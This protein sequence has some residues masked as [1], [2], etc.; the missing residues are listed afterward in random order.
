M[1][2]RMLFIFGALVTLQTYNASA[3]EAT[4]VQQGDNCGTNCSW[5]IDSNNKLTIWATDGE[6]PGSM[7]DYSLD[8]WNLWTSA[9]WKSYRDTVTTVEFMDGI[10][11]IGKEAFYGMKNILDVTIP[12]SVDTF[13]RL[14]FGNMLGPE[15][16]TCSAENLERYLK[17]GL[18]RGNGVIHCTSGDCEQALANGIAANGISPTCDRVLSWTLDT[19]AGSGSG[20]D[21][22]SA[23][24]SDSASD[25]GS[26]ETSVQ[27]ADGSTTLY[28]SDGNV[29]GYRGKRI[30][31]VEEAS[32]LSKETGNTF[33]LR[34]K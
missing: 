7:K 15:S 24:G 28:D 30:Y 32:K 27:N 10:T 5:S 33:K 3:Q 31:T 2:N 20:S 9:P 8:G 18:L 22:G 26:D 16:L 14:P 19:G 25:S 23:S 6:N 1:K 17:D 12:D 11:R 34:Y 21:S 29:T 4:I 13:G